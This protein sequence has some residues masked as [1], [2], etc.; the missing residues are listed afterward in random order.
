MNRIVGSP[1]QLRVSRVTGKPGV[2]IRGTPSSR[3]VDVQIDSATKKSFRPINQQESSR[4]RLSRNRRS[5]SCR[6]SAT[7]RW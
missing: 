1:L 4:N 5:G 2:T 7:A 3:S 6:A